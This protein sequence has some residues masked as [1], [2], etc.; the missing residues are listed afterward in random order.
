MLPTENG[1][2]KFRNANSLGSLKLKHYML[3]QIKIIIYKL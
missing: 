3:P 1:S 2:F